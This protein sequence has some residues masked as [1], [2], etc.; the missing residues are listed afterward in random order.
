MRFWVRSYEKNTI[1]LQVLRYLI[2]VW[3]KN[4]PSGRV[5]DGVDEGVSTAGRLL[6]SLLGVGAVV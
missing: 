6:R 3:T 5:A 2:R 4:Y 1:I